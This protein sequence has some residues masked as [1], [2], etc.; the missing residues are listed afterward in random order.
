VA[1][2][3]FDVEFYLDFS[4]KKRAKIVIPM[5]ETGQAQAKTS[6]EIIHQVIVNPSI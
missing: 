4:P 6:N 2:F 5:P 1:N 3:S